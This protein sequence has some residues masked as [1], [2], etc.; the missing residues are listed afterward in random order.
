MRRDTSWLYRSPLAER[1]ASSRIR[2]P[3]RWSACWITPSAPRGIGT[4]TP[5]SITA[6]WP[7]PDGPSSSAAPSEEL[8]KDTLPNLTALGAAGRGVYLPAN[9]QTASFP[10]VGRRRAQVRQPAGPPQRADRAGRAPGSCPWTITGSRSCS[11]SP[12]TPTM[13]AS[14]SP[15]K[16]SR[17]PGW[18]WPPTRPCAAIAR[19]GW[20]GR[21][22]PESS[23][24]R[25]KEPIDPSNI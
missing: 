21:L 24:L 11:G 16:S 25:F 6:N 9:V 22:R 10:A 20:S 3:K 5:P 17:S 2:S 15:R 13:A 4:A 7:I 23:S 12:M 1:G 14:P 18:P 8:G 19:S